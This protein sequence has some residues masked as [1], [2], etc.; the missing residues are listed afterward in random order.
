M[1]RDWDTIRRILTMI[2]DLPDTSSGISLRDFSED[3]RESIAHHVTLL[4]DAGL[5]S[6]S[7]SRELGRAPTSFTCNRLTWK[8][9]EFLDS[10]RSDTVWQKTKD[11]FKEKGLDMSFELIGSVAKSIA[12]PLLGL[13][14]S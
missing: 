7:L 4:F 9:H 3:E 14:L 5:I 10:I 11:K 2:E 12:G 1:K 13:E 8:G 6:G